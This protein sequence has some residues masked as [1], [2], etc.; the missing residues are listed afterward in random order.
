MSFDEDDAHHIHTNRVK[1][2]ACWNHG[3]GEIVTALVD[4]GLSIRYVHEHRDIPWRALPSMEP[5][6]D[7]T[8]GADGR[9]R[10][11]RMW[12]LPAPQRDLVPLMYSLLAVQS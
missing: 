11:N 8:A 2:T 4:A 1:R 10:S 7:G 6:G 12:R 9:Y 3:L 5:E